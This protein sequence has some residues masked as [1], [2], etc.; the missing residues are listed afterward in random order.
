M[1]S[2]TVDRWDCCV[3][4]T[5]APQP[6]RRPTARQSLSTE[7]VMTAFGDTLRHVKVQGPRWPPEKQLDDVASDVRLSRHSRVGD[8][9]LP[10]IRTINIEC[11]CYSGPYLGDFSSCPKLEKLKIKLIGDPTVGQAY[12]APVW[13]LPHLKT[14]ELSQI[15]ALLFNYDS[16]IIC[17]R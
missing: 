9:N 2:G 8:W 4:G 10:F 3:C 5:F 15:A 12:I 1:G 17:R 6:P 16:W 13:R 14:L 11:R 7:D